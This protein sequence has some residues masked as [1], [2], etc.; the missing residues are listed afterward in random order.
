MQTDESSP[1]GQLSG[2]QGLARVMACEFETDESRANDSK[3]LVKRPTS[4]RDPP[5]GVS[6]LQREATMAIAGRTLRWA[7]SPKFPK[8]FSV[9]RD[10]DLG[11]LRRSLCA[12]CNPM[13]G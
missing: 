1:N 6:A 7:M 3:P 10:L 12:R 9:R 11:G 8:E 4:S 5:T 2:W 13:C